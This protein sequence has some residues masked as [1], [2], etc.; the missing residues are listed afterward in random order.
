MCRVV[1]YH[2]AV[3]HARSALGR[4]TVQLVDKVDS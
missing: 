3:D 2:D 1:S 4:S